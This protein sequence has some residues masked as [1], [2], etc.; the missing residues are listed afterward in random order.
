MEHDSDALCD[1]LPEELEACCQAAERRPLAD[2]TQDDPGASS[3]RCRSARIFA[4]NIVAFHRMKQAARQVRKGPAA[5]RK[6]IA[7]RNS[8]QLAIPSC[9][10]KALQLRPTWRSASWRTGLAWT[11]ASG[12][13]APGS[14]GSGSVS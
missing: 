9:A 3:A 7:R 12:G 10:G 2:I 8:K 6:S 13:A 4:G 14:L 5:G 11:S 1:E